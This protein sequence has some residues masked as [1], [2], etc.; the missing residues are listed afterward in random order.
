MKAVS[1]SLLDLP[2]EIKM[3]NS[4]PVQGKGYTPPNMASPFFEGL[5]CYDMAVPGN[6]DQFLDQLCVSDPH[7]RYGATGDY[8]A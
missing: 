3:R 6:L 2:V 7:Q 1:R 5:G 8:G 4:N